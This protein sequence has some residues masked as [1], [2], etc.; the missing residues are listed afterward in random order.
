MLAQFS[1][2]P[3]GSHGTSLRAPVA[4]AIQEIDKTGIKYRVTDMGTILEG[5]WDAVMRALKAVHDRILSQSDR[6]YMTVSIDDRKDKAMTLDS[7]VR[8]VEQAV[9]K[10]LGA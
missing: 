3:I 7:K 8:A 2:F 4:K 1:V 10:K 5:D 9:G 6:V